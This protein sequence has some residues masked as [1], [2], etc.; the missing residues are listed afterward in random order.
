[1]SKGQKVRVRVG[2][3]TP[4]LAGRPWQAGMVDYAVAVITAA[5]NKKKQQTHTVC[6]PTK[7]SRY[8]VEAGRFHLQILFLSCFII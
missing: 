5:D 4:V 6:I 3:M 7:A 1:M 8:K 2:N